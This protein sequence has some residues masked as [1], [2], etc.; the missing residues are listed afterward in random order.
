MRPAPL[1][2]EKAARREAPVRR[3]WAGGGGLGKREVPP[4]R[5][6]AEDR[7]G[8]AAFEEG[9]VAVCGLSG[10]RLPL[11]VNG[12]G[13]VHG[14]SVAAK[15]SVQPVDIHMRRIASRP[16]P[17]QGAGWRLLVRLPLVDSRNVMKEGLPRRETRRVL[18]KAK[19]GA[20]MSYVG[21]DLSR[22]RLDWQA[23]DRAGE[24]VA[25][26]AVPPDRDGLSRLPQQ[27]GDARCWR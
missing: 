14:G 6:T 1:K 11:H 22:M 25:I 12:G 23:L 24:R 20:C 3:R 26:G 13:S 2:R 19:G 10:R 21:L 15:L 18:T 5:T 9:G 4:A 8:E 17:H 7:P 27:L 16:V